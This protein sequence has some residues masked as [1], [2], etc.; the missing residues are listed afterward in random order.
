MVVSCLRS[1]AVSLRSRRT[2]ARYPYRPASSF[3]ISVH[4]VS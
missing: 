3:R 1:V 4:I 2:G